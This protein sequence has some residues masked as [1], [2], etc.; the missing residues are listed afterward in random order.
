MLEARDNDRGVQY[1]GVVTG[2]FENYGFIES[3][4]KGTPVF[5]H[6]KG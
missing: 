6:F 4:A 5:F 3:Y 1:S 2:I